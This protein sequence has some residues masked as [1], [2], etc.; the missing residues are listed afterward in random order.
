MIIKSCDCSVS[1]PPSMYT[2]KL[3]EKES[4]KKLWHSLSVVVKGE[5]M[6]ERGSSFLNEK[7][8]SAVA[9]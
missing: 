4:K 6:G 5:K 7:H 9:L 2:Q 8:V 1:P 3:R